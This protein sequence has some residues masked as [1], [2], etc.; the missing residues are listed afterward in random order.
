MSDAASNKLRKALH[1]TRHAL[2]PGLCGPSR[3]LRVRGDVLRLQPVRPLW[4]DIEAF[5]AA[6][7][8][9]RP[10]GCTSGS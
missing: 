5:E 3:F 4:V 8:A 1:I 7:D 10:R 6:A 2:E 9:R